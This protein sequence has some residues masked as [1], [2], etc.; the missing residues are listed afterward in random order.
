MG[1]LEALKVKPGEVGE[2]WPKRMLTSILWLHQAWSSSSVAK[3]SSPKSVNQTLSNPST[4]SRPAGLDT[5]SLTC[6][7]CIF[8]I[9]SATIGDVGSLSLAA[10]ERIQSFI[11]IQSRDIVHDKE[12]AFQALVSRRNRA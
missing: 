11:D 2:I 4:L 5:V 12:M 9:I 10:T 1:K 8:S 7:H 6:I 3:G